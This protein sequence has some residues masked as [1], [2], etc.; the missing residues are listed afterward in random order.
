VTLCY[1]QSNA[2]RPPAANRT[3]RLPDFVRPNGPATAA[4]FL[5]VFRQCDPAGNLRRYTELAGPSRKP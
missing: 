2:F 4:A 3:R 1:L 5:F